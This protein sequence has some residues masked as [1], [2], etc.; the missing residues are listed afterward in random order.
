L[1]WCFVAENVSHII[2]TQMKATSFWCFVFRRLL[3][4]VLTPCS[5]VFLEKL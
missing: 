2:L 4:Y 5:T 1:S 3:A